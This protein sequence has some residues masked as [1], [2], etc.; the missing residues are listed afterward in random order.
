MGVKISDLVKPVIKEITINNLLGKKIAI[1][2][3][4]SIFQFLA[5]IR[6]RDGTPLKDFEGNVTSH[7]SG[8]FYRTINLIEQ[9]IKPVYVFDGPPHELK[10]KTIRERREIRE[11]QRKKME[12]ALDSEDQKEARKYA[13]GTS[14]LTSDMIEESKLLLKYMGVPY[15][16]AAHDGEAE[17]ARLV[18][19]GAVWACASQDY[20]SLL[21]GA[22]RLI[23]NLNIN[24]KKKVKNTTI[25]LSIEYIN[26]EAVLKHLDISRQQ[27]VDMGILIGLDFFEGIKGIGEKTALQLIQTHGSIEKI[28]ESGI[29]IKKKPIEIDLDALA[30]VRSIFFQIEKPTIEPV[31]KW[32]NP[33][34]KKIME[35]LCDRHN[36]SRERIENAFER[37]HAKKSQKVQ[38]SLDNYF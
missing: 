4:N 37:L 2:A 15:V 29:C 26:L 1:D 19:S 3:F 20:D 22:K 25:N 27:L 28:I 21:F 10:L 9:D 18:N 6:Q 30:K 31:L 7:L 38:T 5:T 13:Q 11:K 23:R 14:K 34:K 17:A 32:S 35:L 33:N 36:F 24:R 8:L 12:D 16:E